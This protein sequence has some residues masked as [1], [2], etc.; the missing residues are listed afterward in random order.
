MACTIEKEVT[1]TEINDLKTNKVNVFTITSAD[2]VGAVGQSIAQIGFGLI[3]NTAYF[4]LWYSWIGLEFEVSSSHVNVRRY[5][6]NNG[7][8]NWVTII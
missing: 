2:E 3:N 4:E 6:G 8:G 1:Q 7:W 5:Y